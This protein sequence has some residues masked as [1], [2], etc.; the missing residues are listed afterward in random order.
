MV[1]AG[2]LD[3]AAVQR[4]AG[5]SRRIYQFA[6]DRGVRGF[7]QRPEDVLAAWKRK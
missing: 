4:L 3:D 7:P 2:G 6:Y 1:R 5:S